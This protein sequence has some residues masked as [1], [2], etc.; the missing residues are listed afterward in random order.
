MM[1]RC[2]WRCTAVSFG[3]PGGRFVDG[4]LAEKPAELARGWRQVGPFKPFDLL[5]ALARAGVRSYTGKGRL[6][7]I[8]SGCTRAWKLDESRLSHSQRWCGY[9][10]PKRN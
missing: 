10:S 5:E 6:R 8:C 1:V 2:R 3:V 7:S 9:G 4:V